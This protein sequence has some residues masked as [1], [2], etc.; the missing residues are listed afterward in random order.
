MHPANLMWLGAAGAHSV[1]S[2]EPMTALV[3]A[4]LEGVYLIGSGIA[5]T[6]QPT[7]VISR[8]SEAE[9]RLEAL[10]AD[11]S[12]SQ[13][14][15]AETLRDLKGHI[16]A[17]Y[18][19]L[20]GGKL[21]AASSEARLDALLT[22]FVRLLGSLNNYRSHLSNAP[23]KTVEAELKEL[24]EGMQG[25]ANPRLNE[26]KA[27]RVEILEKRLARFQLAEES[28]EV[29][30]HQLAA[31]E[32]LLRLTLEQSISIRDPSSAALQ[33]EALSAGVE[34][35]EETVREMERIMEIGGEEVF[36]TGDLGERE[37][38]R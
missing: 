22:S 21:V 2:G 35:S 10:M 18:R 27:K 12:P 29:V 32:D 20:P 5:A 19:K 33:L 14:Q 24:R 13:R 26:V 34:S 8:D 15:Q 17:N 11:L 4:G 6:R 36:L 9:R 31:I 25:T 1:M 7:K 3:A 38:V 28:R 16:L 23:R 37:R 30:S